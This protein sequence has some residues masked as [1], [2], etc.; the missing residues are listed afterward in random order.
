MHDDVESITALQRCL[1]VYRRTLEFL[2]IQ[3]AQFG[4]FTPPYIWHQFDETRSEIARVKRELRAQGV[5]VDDQP[6]DAEPPAAAPPAAQASHDDGALL[7]TY[8]RM[9]SDQVHYVPLAGMS[10]WGD[11]HPQL[12]ALYVERALTPLDSRSPASY[13]AG[14]AVALAELARAPGA[15][16]LV[17]GE[18]GS[19]KTTCLHALT[20]S[21]LAQ[22]SAGAAAWPGAA[23]LPI[24]L[25][26]HDIAQALTRGNAAP[27]D[28]SMPSLSA[29]WEAI[30]SWLQFS[31]LKDLVPAIQQRLDR[32]ECLVLID[33][34][35][36]L[37][38]TASMSAFM[39]ALGRFV[40]RYPDNRYVVTCRGFQPSVM[41]PLASFARYTLATP[42]AD[43][44][45]ALIRSWYG[46][47][48]D[49][50]G[51]LASEAVERRASQLHQ[52]LQGDARLHSL[53]RTPLTLALCVL[54]HAQGHA[55]P[56]A[57][58]TVL[59]RHADM[60]INGREFGG[61]DHARQLGQRL[62]LGQLYSA[63]QRRELA[64]SLAL[65]LQTRLGS[66]GSATPEL[67][68]AEAAELIGNATARHQIAEELLAWCC[69]HH[70]LQR[71]PRGGY[72][73][74]EAPVRE[75]LAGR[76]LAGM[77]DFP[78][79]A[80]EL[81]CDAH[82]HEP[83]V[84]AVGELGKRGAPHI[85]RLF[86]RL[87]LHHRAAAPA[88]CTTDTQLAA[89]CLIELG[90]R[91]WSDRALRDE[92][93]EQLMACVGQPALALPD[94]IRAGLLLGSLGDPR[95]AGLLPPLARVPAGAFAL[96]TSEG[97]DDEG[98]AQYADLAEFAIGIFLVTN[99]EYARFLAERPRHPQPHYWHDPRVNNPS[100]PVV[101]VTWHDANA[102]CEWLTAR[103]RAANLIGESQLVR[104]PTELEWEKAASWDAGRQAKRRF[105]WGDGWSSEQ[106]N[107][108]EARGF[109]M[110]S[111]VGCYP[112]G[113]SPYGLH[114][115]V[116][117]V[118]E[119]T[120]SPYASY[121]GAARPFCEAEVYTLRGSSCAT[122]PTHARCTYRSR[123]PPSYWRNHL[124]F[125]VVVAQ[126]P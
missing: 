119:W 80:Y 15:R 45:L 104:L 92:V 116:G 48:A 11:L 81:R 5:E 7:H 13:T 112:G 66:A 118:W 54:A 125:R 67:S 38:S 96:G 2:E 60:L 106:A 29:F 105:P 40:A 50:A 12:A 84:H 123:L 120:G 82:W 23:P 109:W 6:A 61:H 117:N 18:F 93:R 17:E 107:T 79:R 85:A 24:L 41:A 51:L 88:P 94:R 19:G 126:Q 3:R 64:E 39:I 58:S 34:M 111:P 65:A 21:C 98:P 121:P 77:A 46:C 22:A 52:V 47:V 68:A 26:G 35:D 62:G 56:A 115:C 87:L 103:L 74:P 1:A 110:T 70:L 72:C 9:L 122:N 31:N 42:D 44:A 102:Y 30:E 33:D 108:A 69:A 90:E 113:T 20:L 73:M 49:R 4:A 83:I 36:D 43:Q 97:Y 78:T 37:P 124:G 114:D 91:S 101:G 16:M 14:T 71:T 75:Y 99:Q 32:G 100:C 55:L 95:F 59:L 57:R 25:A 76:A 63:E 27:N 89:E 8:Q 53:A 10:D 28:R 86:V